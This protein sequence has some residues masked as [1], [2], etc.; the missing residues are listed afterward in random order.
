MIPIFMRQSPPRRYLKVDMVASD[1][2]AFLYV[3][4]FLAAVKPNISSLLPLWRLSQAR[5]ETV[6]ICV[7]EEV[8]AVM[9]LQVLKRMVRQVLMKMVQQVSALLLG[10][11]VSI[12]ES[13]LSWAASAP[14]EAQLEPNPKCTRR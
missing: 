8:A 11:A 12:G 14:L 2:P 13:E 10:A 4:Q 6:L 3:V 9:Q 1:P 5:C 7:A